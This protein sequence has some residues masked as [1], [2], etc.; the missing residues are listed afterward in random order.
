[1]ADWSLR[2]YRIHPGARIGQRFLIDHGTGVV[3]GETT[4]IGDDVM[5]YHQVTLASPDGGKIARGRV[6]RHPTIEDHVVIGVG[7]TILG[8]IT[9]GRHSK[10]GALSLVLQDVPP[11]SVVV[12]TPAQVLKRGSYSEVV[13]IPPADPQD[14]R[15][16][17]L[18]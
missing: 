6:K 9:I 17:V 11:N 3:I 15:Q 14:E 7:A 13:P 18:A 2:R 16:R 4:E 1:M 12:S 8:P 10:I 5:L